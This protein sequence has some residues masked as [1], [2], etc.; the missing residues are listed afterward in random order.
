MIFLA[1][2]SLA[3]S[4]L[5]IATWQPRNM[6]EW[7]VMTCTTTAA[8]LLTIQAHTQWKAGEHQHDTDTTSEEVR[9]AD[10]EGSSVE[11]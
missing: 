9:T 7:L 5:A 4:G 8:T 11:V 10:D 2:A 6:I 3:W 1:T